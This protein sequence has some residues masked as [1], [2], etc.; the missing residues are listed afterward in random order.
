MVSND[1]FNPCTHE[2]NVQTGQFLMDQYFQKDTNDVA[3]Q[4]IAIKIVDKEIVRHSIM[5]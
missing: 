3:T 5:I 1:R 2:E 4:S